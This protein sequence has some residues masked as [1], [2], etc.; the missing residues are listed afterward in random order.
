GRVRRGQHDGE[1]ENNSEADLINREAPGC[2]RVTR[3]QQNLNLTHLRICSGWS[4]SPWSGG[5]ATWICTLFGS[6]LGPWSSATRTRLGKAITS[7]TITS[8]IPT[9]GIEPQ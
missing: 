8:W 4:V 2:L 3:V 6:T 9:K 1:E 7:V 5:G